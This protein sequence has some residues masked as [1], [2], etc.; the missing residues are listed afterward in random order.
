MSDD[1]SG[2][3]GLSV[4]R[5]TKEM[6][7]VY[8]QMLHKW[9]SSINLIAQ[10]TVKNMYQRH[11]LDSLQILE[12]SGLPLGLWADFGSGGGLPGLLVAIN[13]KATGKHRSVILVESDQ[14]KATFL[15]EVVRVLGLD[16]EVI[17]RRVEDISPI[18]ANVVSA[19]ALATLEQLCGFA[20]THLAVGGMGVFHKGENRAEE[21]LAA[22][23]S[24]NFDMSEV[25]SVTN[26]N[27][28]IL[29]VRDIRHA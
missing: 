3:L 19:R 6:L 4:S 23:R 16:A 29:Y 7:D 8:T 12:Y 25:P 14:R 11:V 26:P 1:V 5:E 17:S 22:R 20:A 28:A 18:S 21:I 2:S 15:R 13:A 24:W 10:S 9:N 27:A